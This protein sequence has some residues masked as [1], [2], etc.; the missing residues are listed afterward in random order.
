V[1]DVVASETPVATASDAA[2]ALEARGVS[3]VY[4]AGAARTTIFENLSLSIEL[5][6]FVSLVGAS[7]CGK[8]TLL[9]AMAGL[10][11]PDT[12]EIYYDGQRT[13]GPRREIIYI[14]QQYTK[15]IF[16]WLT[17][18]V[19]VEFGI[20]HRFNVSRRERRER[21]RHFLELVGLAGYESHYPRQ[22]SGG[23]QQ[24]V[25][26]ARAIA[27][28]PRVLLMDEPFSAVDALTRTNLQQLVLEL[29]ESM[30]LTV[31]FVTHDV[32]EAVFLS[33]RVVVMA[34]RPATFVRDTKIEL[35]YPRATII[36]PEDP[37]YHEAR[38]D[39]LSE[40]FTVERIG[41]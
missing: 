27:C 28:E 23:M 36:T 5:G 29:W 9:L 15:S 40:I 38:H 37:R 8:S 21:A 35:P 13:A 22:L 7:G 10:A 20:K 30:G 4:G 6:S 41:A 18:A 34:G 19:N 33:S 32:D 31:L 25:A 3:R 12:G 17:V 2:H 39:I 24:R 26:L 11:R 14:F 1:S 16:S